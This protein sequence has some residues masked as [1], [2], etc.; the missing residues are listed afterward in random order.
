[1]PTL[2]ILVLV[3]LVL[4]VLAALLD[5]LPRSVKSYARSHGKTTAKA[6][7][8]AIV[9]MN[10][11]GCLPVATTNSPVQAT[12]AGEVPIVGMPGYSLAS[13]VVDRGADNTHYLYILKKDGQVMSGAGTNFSAGKAGNRAMSLDAG[14]V[15]GSSAV[16]C[17][18]ADD[19]AAMA[20]ALR[21]EEALNDVRQCASV[22]DCEQK[23]AR[24]RANA[25][26]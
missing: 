8:L 10:L 25:G 6:A 5:P 2:A 18:S 16:M 3:V 1:M 4:L 23:I 11:G 21:A 17:A 19:C 22:E 12:A 15:G 20:R 26:K 9:L 7:A 13:I 24:M 14:A